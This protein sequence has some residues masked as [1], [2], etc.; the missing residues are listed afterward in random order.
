V[1]SSSLTPGDLARYQATTAR[2]HLAIVREVD[3]DVAEVEFFWGQRQSVSLEQL[4]RFQDYLDTRERVL[5]LKRTALCEAFFG[6]PL[7]RLREER[8]RKLQGTL[9]QFGL[10]F[11]PEQ[12]PTPATRVQI[13]RDDSVV[14]AGGRGKEAKFEALLPRW[15]EPLKLPPS[16]RDPLGL[17]APAERLAN[18]LLPGLT[19][20]TSRIG[21]Y[22]FLA[23]AVQCVNDL[24][25]PSHQTRQERLHRLERALVLC[26]F[27]NH[28][29]GDDSCP[30]L[31]QRSKT[32]VLQGAEGDRYRVP[33]RIL[34]NQAS[35]GAY[36]LYFTSLQSL[37]ITQEAP[38]LGAEGLLPLTLTN[39]GQRLA[40]AF[41]LRLDHK[42]ADF[43]L[44]DGPLDRDTIR[45]WGKDVCFCR[46]GGLARYRAP[47]LEGF[48]LG[49]SAE[50]EKRYRT[51]QRL[52][53]GQLLTGTYEQE[54][55]EST[56]AGALPEEAA[57]AVEAV[58]EVV[59]L[60]NDRVLLHFYEKTPQA[61]NRDF[62]VSAVFELLALGL[63]ALFQCVVSELRQSGRVR[64]AGL[65]SRIASEGRLIKL[66]TL[67]L[68][69]IGGSSP[70]ARTLVRRLLAATEP[71]HRA[72][73]GGVLLAR[74]LG[75]RALAAVG[76]EL[77][78]NPA[79]L[80]ADATLRSRP[81]RSLL[82]AFPEV[83]G[84]MVDRHQA[85]SLNKNRQRWC[86]LDGD[87]VVKD[88]L[89]EM[90]VGLHAFRFPQ[91]FSLCWDLGLQAKDLR[92]GA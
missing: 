40:H 21:Y 52:F 72:A 49:N 25:C 13:W 59:G 4:F 20:F 28:G 23:W 18:E 55:A 89:Q 11:R 63:S 17:Q 46:I 86:Y 35:A 19:V 16:S 65:A 57:T 60:G 15:L 39:L 84:A 43:A 42:F 44:G 61:D 30:L 53:Q 74:V 71:I 22:G 3:G 79:L 87:V 81:E 7:H 14:L 82:E 64:P 75:D 33:K 8:V 6:D 9:R 12:W 80:L 10:S 51:V 66:W 91:L 73:L 36:R 48:L 31:G 67:P 1:S 5:S 88:D 37:G 68:G 76:D 27:V 85:V 92:H 24:P 69:A 56:D 62:Q 41:Q 83:V 26:E 29:L 32:Q 34:K 2:W 78:A 90:Q 47:F 38:E 70:K 77:A 54:A 58:P 45:S 50:A